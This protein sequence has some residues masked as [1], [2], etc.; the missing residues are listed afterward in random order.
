MLDALVH[1]PTDAT[2]WCPTSI[3]PIEN[4]GDFHTTLV[5]VL[6]AVFSFMHYTGIRSKQEHIGIGVRS[7]CAAIAQYGFHATLRELAFHL[8]IC[9]I[10]VNLVVLRRF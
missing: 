3:F 5:N 8:V 7:G 4:K 6:K 9:C 10:V 1:K 2:A